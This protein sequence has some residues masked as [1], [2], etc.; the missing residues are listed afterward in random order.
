M[1]ENKES[2]KFKDFDTP[3]EILLFINERA[4]RHTNY[5]H[6]TSLQNVNNILK[7]K[8]LWLSPL[9]KSSNDKIEKEKYEEYEK[10]GN[11]LFSVCFSTGTSESLPL[12]YLY[13]GIDGKGARIE[14]K[15]TL[16]KKLTSNS[17]VSLAEK[18]SDG[19]VN[20]V[21]KLD[22]NSCKL[23]CRDIL[24]LG[25]DTQNKDLYRCK[26]NGDAKNGL[27]KDFY[28]ALTNEYGQFIKT[29]IWFYEKETRVQVEI[30][31][32]NLIEKGKNYVVV[33]N[34]K[35][36]LPDISVRLGPEQENET[37]EIINS[38][39]G[40]REWVN[41]KLLKSDFD[42]QIKMNLKEK[43]CENC[44]YK[45]AEDSKSDSKTKE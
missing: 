25:S 7:S 28:N 1:M 38:Y 26:Y 31:D 34:L 10:S 14:F 39:D 44:D 21:K 8:Q 24:Y 11:S 20:I 12:W 29:L 15:K 2:K 6:Y 5:Y 30:T 37:D 27:S 22:E 45:K 13:S 33:I 40:I 43:L 35:D 42:G 3:E 16:F 4:L 9:S 23:S 19:N 17:E 41:S 18:L 32:K 36:I